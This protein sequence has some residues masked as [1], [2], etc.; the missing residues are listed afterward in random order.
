M[1]IMYIPVSSRARAPRSPSSRRRCPSP[2]SQPD[3]AHASAAPRRFL[4]V[5]F[6]ARCNYTRSNQ[7]TRC[8]NYFTP[9]HLIQLARL[10]RR[11]GFSPPTVVFEATV[12]DFRRQDMV[13]GVVLCVRVKVIAVIR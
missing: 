9:S 6:M 11:D 5:M 13:M 8:S 10:Q 7:Q 12:S 4:L 3:S 2:S 1:Y